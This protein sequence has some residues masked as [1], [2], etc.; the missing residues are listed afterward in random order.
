[1]FG[2]WQSDNTFE[3]TPAISSTGKTAGGWYV[4]V[5]YAHTAHSYCILHIVYSYCVLLLYTPTA[6]SYCIL[7]TAYFILHTAYCILQRCFSDWTRWNLT[8]YPGGGSVHEAG[9]WPA[10]MRAMQNSSIQAS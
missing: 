6:Y 9:G 3:R 7:H 1:M 8:Q 4:P 2:A 10:R 5:L